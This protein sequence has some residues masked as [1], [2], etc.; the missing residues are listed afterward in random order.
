[1]VVSRQGKAQPSEDVSNPVLG[2]CP[3]SS[4]RVLDEEIKKDKRREMT[5]KIRRVEKGKQ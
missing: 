5:L 2:H 3:T 1:M 4:C